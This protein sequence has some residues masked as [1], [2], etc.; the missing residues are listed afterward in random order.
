MRCRW[1]KQAVRESLDA[2]A[3]LPLKVFFI[4]GGPGYYQNHPFGHSGWPTLDD[5]LEMLEWDECIGMN[6]AFAARVVD[7]ED[8]IISLVE[9][10]MQPG[11]GYA[12]TARQ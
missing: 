4:L 8:K 12:V 1:G 10:V 11:S 6:E 9:G 3:D 7:D 5:M 2:A